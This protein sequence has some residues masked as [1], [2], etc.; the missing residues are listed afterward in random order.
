MVTQSAQKPAL[1]VMT[2][3][4]SDSGGGAGIQ[5]DLKT[6]A[7][8]GVYGTSAITAITAQNTREVTAVQTVDLPIICAQIDAI[9]GD[10]GTD[11][12]KVGMLASA[13]IVDLVA[14]KLNELELPNIVVDPVMVATSGDRLLKESAIDALKM[15]LIPLATVVTPNLDEAMALTGLDIHD[16]DDMQEAAQQ[17]HKLGA[18]TVLVK[19]GHFA[20]VPFETGTTPQMSDVLYDGET[21]TIFKDAQIPTTS[22]HGTGCTLSSAIA[23]GLS[24]GRPVADAIADAK[25]YL[26]DTLS[27]SFPIGKGQGPVNHLFGWWSG[28]G[29]NGKG[30]ATHSV[31]RESG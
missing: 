20:G 6:F 15:S 29:A 19:G 4:G 26:T 7:A 9:V 28:G 10:I 3:A 17:I 2:I 18:Q 30:G 5:A 1:R 16:L 8:F 27:N 24:R 25:A 22:T 11:A 14:S 23:A 31:T 12:V 21:F 13:E